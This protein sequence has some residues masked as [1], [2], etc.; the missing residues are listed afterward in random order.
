MFYHS[1]LRFRTELRTAHATAF[2][3]KSSFYLESQLLGGLK[4]IAAD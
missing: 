2:Y 4:I 1:N 3:A